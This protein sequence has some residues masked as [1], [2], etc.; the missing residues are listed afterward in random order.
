MASILVAA[1]CGSNT[2]SPR[3]V[4]SSSFS[5]TEAAGSADFRLVSTGPWGPA[6]SMGTTVS[7]GAVNFKQQAVTMVHS[8]IG[9]PSSLAWRVIEIGRTEYDQVPRILGCW[10]SFHKLHPLGALLLP[11]TASFESDK[12][13]KIGSVRLDG[14]ALTKYQVQI[15]VANQ[16]S[17]RVAAHA[18]DLW[19]D[20]LGRLR[21]EA[22]N[23][24]ETG[25]TGHPGPE[26]FTISITFS[27]F[28]TPVHIHAPTACRVR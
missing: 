1:A 16:G 22:E 23:S 11:V 8:N 6:G 18:L 14:V 2:A 27:N 13:A 19:V 9:E 5:R 7:V 12:V 20:A 15:P 24:T 4:V 3:S 10:S 17:V 28:G 21:E 25:M 26:T